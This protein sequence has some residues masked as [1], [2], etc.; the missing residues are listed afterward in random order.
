MLEPES[1]KNWWNLEFPST[2]GIL[3]NTSDVLAGNW[4]AFA[5][6]ISENF[7]IDNDPIWNTV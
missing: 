6:Q 5:L 4:D 3:D 7:T 2:P 1:I